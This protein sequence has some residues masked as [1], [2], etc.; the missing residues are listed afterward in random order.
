M[1]LY[2]FLFNLLQWNNADYVV[3][4]IDK[5]PT[6]E[7]SEQPINYSLKTGQHTEIQTN[8]NSN[9]K[10]TQQQQES[11]KEVSENL[12]HLWNFW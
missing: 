9:A 12:N 5:L 2:L 7:E 8:L 3:M 11:G 6:N 10:N 1:S 4:P